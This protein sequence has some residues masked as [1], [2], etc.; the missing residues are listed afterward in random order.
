MCVLFDAFQILATYCQ[1]NEAELSMVRLHRG[2][3]CS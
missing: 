2:S 1:W 3:T